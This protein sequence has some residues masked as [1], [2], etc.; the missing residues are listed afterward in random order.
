MQ[1][2]FDA[3]VNGDEI[4]IRSRPIGFRRV[5]GTWLHEVYRATTNTLI[6]R[7]Y[8]IGAFLDWQGNV[9][10]GPM[11]ILKSLTRGESTEAT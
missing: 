10:A 9:R 1:N 5:R 8:S 3:A 2:F 7:D 11:E 4:E 6:M